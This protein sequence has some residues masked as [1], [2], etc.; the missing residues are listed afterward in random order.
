MWWD[1]YCKRSVHK[2]TEHRLVCLGYVYFVTCGYT[3]HVNSSA[4]PQLHLW[5]TMWTFSQYEVA[6]IMCTLCY[7]AEHATHVAKVI[8]GALQFFLC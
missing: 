8:Q 6:S 5:C 1:W 2:G 3:V 4:V 7:E